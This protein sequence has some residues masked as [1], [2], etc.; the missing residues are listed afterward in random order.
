MT[1]RISPAWWPIIGLSSPVL[2]P[3]LL[4]KNRRF[5]QNIRKAQ[6]VNNERIERAEHLGLGVGP[7]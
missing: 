2:F 7:R 6:E 1:Y 4:V 3:M 5:K